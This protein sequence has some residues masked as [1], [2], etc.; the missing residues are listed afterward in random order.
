MNNCV[1]YL[2]TN[3]NFTAEEIYDIYWQTCPPISK[4]MSVTAIVIFTSLLCILWYFDAMNNNFVLPPAEHI[5]Y[6]IDRMDPA[7]YRSLGL[8]SIELRKQDVIELRKQ[9]IIEVIKRYFDVEITEDHELFSVIQ[10][11]QY[12]QQ[13]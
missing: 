6:F 3:N 10:G 8:T 12:I 13:T 5:A 2:P 7:L 1:I 9:D 11:K 4:T